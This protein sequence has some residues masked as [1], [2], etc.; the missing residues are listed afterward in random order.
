MPHFY[1]SFLLS[2]LVAATHL[3]YTNASKNIH[4]E[5]EN[6]MIDEMR[7]R[8]AAGCSTYLETNEMLHPG[9]YLCNSYQDAFFKLTNSCELHY[10]D[11]YFDCFDELA[12]ADIDDDYD[13][14]LVMQDDGNVVLYNARRKAVWKTKTRGKNGQL[15]MSNNGEV[16]LQVPIASNI[17]SRSRSSPVMEKDD[18]KEK[19][20]NTRKEPVARG[21]DCYSDT[22]EH[23]DKLR[24]LDFIC[25]YHDGPMFGINREGYLVARACRD[26]DDHYIS[27]RYST[28]GYVQIHSDGNLVF[29]DENARV[30]WESET[31]G[32]NSWVG[33]VDSSVYVQT[34]VA[35]C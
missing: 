25:A 34:V 11:I 30:L 9:D 19:E 1:K 7:G 2:S 18:T 12:E 16:V 35:G 3:P 21:I 24:L 10:D 20:D 13:C 14:S 27:R 5:G 15:F 31:R 32:E 26:C 22:L 29:Y 17:D 8:R 23:G 33:F 6:N 28:S 4:R